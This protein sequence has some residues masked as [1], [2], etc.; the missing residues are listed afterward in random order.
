MSPMA[1]SEDELPQEKTKK[2]RK[3]RKDKEKSST[4]KSKVK[5]E[6]SESKPISLEIQPQSQPIVEESSPRHIKLMTKGVKEEGPILSEGE[7]SSDQVWVN[8]FSIN[9][10]IRVETQIKACLKVSEVAPFVVNN[11]AVNM[12]C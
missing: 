5:E 12:I 4:K 7:I 3:S 6:R 8:N 9:I 1:M 2:E 11:C 10:N